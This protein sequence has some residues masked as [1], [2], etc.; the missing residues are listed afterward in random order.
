MVLCY[1]TMLVLPVFTGVSV[2]RAP[3][4]F[5][6]GD[7]ISSE[8]STTIYQTTRFHNPQDYNIN[9]VLITSRLEQ[10]IYDI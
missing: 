1:D 9:F 3:L 2:E 10:T 6:R 4:I 8:T 7:R 5:S